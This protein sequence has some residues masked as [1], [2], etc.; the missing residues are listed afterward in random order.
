MS[1]FD[2]KVVLVTGGT[3]GI[4][5]TTAELFSENGARVVISGRRK[6]LGEQIAKDIGGMF[7]ECDVS[8]EE[9]VINML[10]IVKREY[11]H[12]DIAFN[13]AGIGG[14]RSLITETSSEKM[15]LVIDTNLK[16]VWF[17][18]KYEIPLMPEGSAIVNMASVVGL[19]GGSAFAS[20]VASKHAVIGLTKSAAVEFGPKKIR[21]NAVCPAVIKTDMTK[22]TYETPE[23]EQQNSAQYPIGRLG[24]TIEVAETVLW[25]SS[26]KSSFV[27]GQSIVIDGGYTAK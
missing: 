18:M 1:E 17:S 12:L 11:G 16:G 19:I 2:N 24:E 6:E 13:N 20:Y 26:N 22:N 15:H 14:E 4:G 10:D 23:K 8:K 27:H 25:L 5:K 3:S 7:V 21:V 9:D